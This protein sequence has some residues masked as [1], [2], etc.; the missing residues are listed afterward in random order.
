MKHTVIDEK[1]CQY[2]NT[3]FD[4]LLKT[5]LPSYEVR[6]QQYD[7]VMKILDSLF[8]NKKLVIE[9]PTGVGKSVGYLIPTIFFKIENLL[10]SRIIVSTYT[11]T[12]Q[13]QLLNKD[14]PLVEKIVKDIFGQELNFC[15]LY[16]SENYVCLHKFVELQSLELLS[17]EEKMLV[18][19][20]SDWLKITETGC[21][22]EIAIRPDFW[23]EI[24]REPDLCRNKNCSFYKKCF[25][26]KN[27]DRAKSADVVVVNH[28]LFFANI[29]HSYKLLPKQNKD[30]EDIIIFDEA[31]NLEE[32]A[33]QWLGASI[34]NT[35]IKFLCKQIYNP[36]KNR[37]LVKQLKSLPESW[38]NNL[39]LA[40]KNVTAANGQFF[41]E[42]ITKLPQKS[43]VRVFE[44][45]IVEDSLTPAL[46]ELLGVLK[47]G[48]NFSKDELEEFKLKSFANRVINFISIINL[49]LKCEDKNFIYWVETEYLSR[50]TKIVLNITPLEIAKDM[51]EKVYCE[52]D[53]II[54]T[55]ATLSVNKSLDFFKKSVG[56]L[57]K[58]CDYNEIEEM[59]LD[60]PFDFESNV[61]LYL[62][63]SVPDPKNEEKDYRKLVSETIKEMIKITSGNT[64]VL[65]TSYEMMRWV[66]EQ[67]KNFD[68]MREYNILIQEG[69]KYKLLEKYHSVTNPVL[70][71]VET[72][73]Q[74]VDIPGEKLVSII[75]PRLPFDVP[76]HPVIE[77]KLEKIKLDGGDP[78]KE[79]SLPNAII[80]LKQGFGRLVRRKTDW[81]IVTIIDP[82][83]KTRW[84]G[85][86]FLNS[87]PKCKVVNDVETIKNFYK[88]K[89]QVKIKT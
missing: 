76:Q 81:G 63:Q 40:V 14:L 65:F 55:S 84:Y 44:P 4:K 43:E 67:I 59:V 3:V 34:A 23:E 5:H 86:Y 85:K 83:I 18:E 48:I 77:A 50:G 68:E 57:P 69:A 87:L 11:K 6:K 54:F 9:A 61:I 53:K 17:N 89:K 88:E 1:T 52:Y 21:L 8:K 32:V 38:K 16:G 22:E 47:S 25:Y 73:W 41:S 75:I 30:L 33:L 39:I 10:N 20:I 72:F 2:I 36:K 60:S 74:G 28:H 82:R 15:C 58:V 80:K 66:F 56:L 29:I 35:Q 27:L 71:G 13:Q 31:H 49:W 7:M 79:Y 37:G 45:N 51:Q 62:P 26:F 42:L 64:F 12:L 19:E 24:N 78:F 46:S 70:F